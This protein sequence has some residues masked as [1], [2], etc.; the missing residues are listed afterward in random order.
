MVNT[1]IVSGVDAEGQAVTA[2]SNSHSLDVTFNPVLAITANWPDEAKVGDTIVYSFTLSHD[3]GSD[4]SPVQSVVVSDTLTGL[5][6]LSSGDDGNNLLETGENWVYRGTYTIL[7]DDSNPL[8]NPLSVV[9]E[10]QDAHAVTVN[11]EYWLN[12]NPQFAPGTNF[13]YLPLIITGGSVAPAPGT[14]PDLVIQEVYVTANGVDVIISNIGDADVTTSFWVDLY[15]D[16]NPV[17]TGVN[18][19]WN[20]G[21]SAQ[22]IMW[23]VTSAALPLKAGTSMTLSNNDA[24]Y[25]SASSISWPLPD[26]TPVYVQVDSANEGVSYGAILETHE[27]SNGTYNNIAGPVVPLN[28][29]S[30]DRVSSTAG[31][32]LADMPDRP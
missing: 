15:V 12:V 5:M 10:D 4:G 3:A 18:Q 13:V 11:N 32:S 14:A 23:G 7:A 27:I 25:S 2:T 29:L 20:D 6:P 24:Y 1:A 9:Y 26:N 16:P 28:N 19:T 8:P 17:P 22:G 21:R 30:T 31:V